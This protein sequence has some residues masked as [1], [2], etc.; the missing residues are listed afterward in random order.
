MDAECFTRF[1]LAVDE[2][3]RLFSCL[4]RL[5][6]PRRAWVESFERALLLERWEA[7]GCAGRAEMWARC[8]REVFGC[9]PPPLTKQ[10]PHIALA[11]FARNRHLGAL[12]VLEELRVRRRADVYEL[13]NSLQGAWGRDHVFQRW[14]ALIVRRRRR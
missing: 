2:H 5:R 7:L 6:R 11:L 12:M 10:A 8:W 13:F 14:S 9:A 4:L 1:I 3:L